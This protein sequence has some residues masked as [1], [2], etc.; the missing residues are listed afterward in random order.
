M[1]AS[2][3]ARA[4]LRPDESSGVVPPPSPLVPAD[5]SHRPLTGADARRLLGLGALLFLAWWL[6]NTLGMTLLLFAASALLA[7]VLNPLVVRLERRGL[8]RGLAV[9]LAVATVMVLLGLAGWLLA[10][11]L[12]DQVHELTDRAPKAAATLRQ[13]AEELAG[14]YPALADALPSAEE[15][16]KS[17]PERAGGVAKL[18]LRS[19]AGV[20]GGMAA[21]VLAAVIAGFILTDPKPLISGYLQLWPDRHREAGRRT[22][23]RMM[24]QMTAWIRGVCINGAI[25]GTSTALLLWLIGVKPALLFGFFAFLGEFVPNIGPVATSLPALFVAAGQGAG[26]FGLAL[27]AILFVQQVETALLVPLIMGK[28]LD[29]HPVE[30]FFWTLAA[31]TLFGLV[32]ALLAVPV[33]ALARILVDEFYLRPRHLEMPAIEAAAGR[34]AKGETDV[35]K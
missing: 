22:L 12:L 26:T 31:G 20:L 28:E 9:L 30:L 27:A 10:P 33:A 14:R 13:R 24:R 32:G 15:L 11:A 1:P 18:L 5:E 17:V 8:K 7:M 25:T 21:V 19:T 3:R 23:A 16:A 2:G 35:A 29:L 6:V 4:T 34:L